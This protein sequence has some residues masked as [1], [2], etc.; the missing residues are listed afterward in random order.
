MLDYDAV[1]LDPVAFPAEYSV[2][3]P[4]MYQ[5][6]RCIS[7]DESPRLLADM[8]RRRKEI[9]EMLA[10]GRTVLIFTPDESSCAVDTGDRRHSGTGRSRVTTTIVTTVRVVD[11]VPLKLVVADAEGS[12]ISVSAGGPLVDFWKRVG[13]QTMYRAIIENGPGTSFLTLT[14]TTK[15][16][17]AAVTAEGGG[18][19][20]LVPVIA[21]PDDATLK[22][23]ASIDKNFVDAFIELVRANS[24]T[25]LEVPDW[26]DSYV[27]PDEVLKRRALQESEHH[28]DSLLAERDELQLRLARAREPKRLIAATG[29]ALEDAVRWA[30]HALG[31]TTLS[32]RPARTDFVLECAAGVA[33]VEVKGLTKSAAEANAAQLEK[34][35]SEYVEE[36]GTVPKAI[37][38]V[39]AYREVPP[40]DRDPAF[41]PQMLPYAQRRG[42]CLMTGL[43]LLGAVRHALDDAERRRAVMQEIFQTDGVL[44]RFG[45]WGEFLEGP[46]AVAPERKTASRRRVIAAATGQPTEDEDVRIVNLPSKTAG[47]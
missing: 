7:D 20:Y 16:V 13:K 44:Q 22:S 38:V 28:I 27:L 23:A 36:H 1:I 11:L 4:P 32:G 6:R 5:G 21:Y 43:Q 31:A 8:A 45:D 46:A 25:P 39:N 18:H 14:G 30:F 40:P 47:G 41:P 2:A 34:W 3:F 24:S 10:L 12:A 37:L 9:E 33:V 42:H 19:L 26:Y 17:G 29:T 15:S 35:V